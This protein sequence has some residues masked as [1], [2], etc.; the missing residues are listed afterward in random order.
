LY[1]SVNYYTHFTG[2]MLEEEIGASLWGST[3]SAT[4]TR[5]VYLNMYIWKIYLEKCNR[6]KQKINFNCQIYK[7]QD[8]L[9]MR[10]NSFASNSFTDWNFFKIFSRLQAHHSCAWLNTNLRA[11]L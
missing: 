9:Y 11:N 2:F 5:N 10:E 1:D 4:R 6:D 7:M 8:G 3:S